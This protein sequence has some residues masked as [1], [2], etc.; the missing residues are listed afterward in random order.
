[1]L[2]ERYQREYWDIKNKRLSCKEIYQKEREQTMKRWH[3]LALIT[4]GMVAIQY[5]K[6]IIVQINGIV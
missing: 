6:I 3:L 1:M 4:I 5:R 2:S